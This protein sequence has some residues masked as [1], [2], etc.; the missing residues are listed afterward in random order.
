M[1]VVFG[2]VDALP[3]KVNLQEITPGILVAD[4]ELELSAFPVSHRGPGCYGFVF[5]EKEKRPFLAEKAEA[6]GVP[7]GP[8]R[9]DLVQGRPVTLADGRVVHPDEVLGPT[10]PGAKLVFVGDIGRTE[11]LVAVAAG[12]TTLVIEA[13][14]LDEEMDM[15][16]R[17]G[18]LTAGTCSTVARPRCR[19]WHPDPEP[20]FATLLSAAGSGRGTADL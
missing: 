1:A 14:Y 18:H 19:G 3:M 10:V 17:F 12:A 5:V 16:R 8:I 13:T 11:D 15:A 6:L 4:D 2:T 20:S 7:S 9:H